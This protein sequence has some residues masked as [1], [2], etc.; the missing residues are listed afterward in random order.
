MEESESNLI[1]NSK[2]TNYIGYVQKKF[3]R[4][5]IPLS[6]YISSFASSNDSSKSEPKKTNKKGSKT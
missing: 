2:A 6:S 5:H 3:Q 1:H 4:M